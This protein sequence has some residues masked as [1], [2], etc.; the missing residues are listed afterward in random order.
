MVLCA[1]NSI[2]L[3]F[4]QNRVT[5][6]ERVPLGSFLDPAFRNFLLTVDVNVIP[7][8]LLASLGLPSA[9]F[10][11]LGKGTHGFNRGRNCLPPLGQLTFPK[12]G[13]HK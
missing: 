10:K 5:R 12:P 13:L 6:L 8:L 11:I 9:M 2:F 4:V 3:G 1:F 7:G